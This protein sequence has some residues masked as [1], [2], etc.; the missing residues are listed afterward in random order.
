MPATKR[1]GAS[2][3][4]V[5]AKL[6]ELDRSALLELVHNLY[7]AG[8]ENQAFLHM[9]FGV[10]GEVLKPY[11]TTISRWLWPDVFRGQDISVAKA[12]KA[13]ADYRKANGQPY[14][15]AELAVFFCEQASGF[16]A[17]CRH[18]R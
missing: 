4:D 11:Q 8:K 17:E 3:S 18:G 16:A 14:G 15:L 1:S 2:W 12:R 6:T 10:G 7:A 5:K 13:I 9:R